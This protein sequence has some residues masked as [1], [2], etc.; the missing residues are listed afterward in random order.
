MSNLCFM[1]HLYQ[2]NQIFILTIP[3]YATKQ[4][5]QCSEYVRQ[6]PTDLTKE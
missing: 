2:R 4:D 5:M 1:Q 3:Y 6:M